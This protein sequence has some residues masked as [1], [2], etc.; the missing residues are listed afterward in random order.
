MSGWS[1]VIIYRRDLPEPENPPGEVVRV[2]RDQRGT[3][4]ESRSVVPCDTG[5]TRTSVHQSQD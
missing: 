3:K 1:G 5:D 4:P 2:Y